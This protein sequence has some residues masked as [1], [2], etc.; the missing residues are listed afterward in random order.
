MPTVN[1]VAMPMSSISVAHVADALRRACTSRPRW[2][3]SRTEKA[4]RT[5]RIRVGVSAKFRQLIAESGDVAEPDDGE[6]RERDEAETGRGAKGE[7]QREVADHRVVFAMAANQGD[8]HLEVRQTQGAEDKGEP[9][10]DGKH[11]QRF[12]RISTLAHEEGNGRL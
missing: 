8:D 11:R 2:H 12:E 9:M 5:A 1:T 3:A 4:G 10:N 6:G 7:R